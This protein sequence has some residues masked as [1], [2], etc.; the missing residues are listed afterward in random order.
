MVCFSKGSTH[1]LCR[2]HSMQ[3][4]EAQ[5]KQYKED[6]YVVVP[7]LIALEELVPVRRRLMELL[8][9][10]HDWPNFHFQVLDPERFRNPRGGLVPV[11]VQGPAQRE[12]IFKNIADH[13][14]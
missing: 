1:T 4:T 7:Q 2:R 6:G 3:L 11:G 13:P 14:H 10:D 5:L 8:E 12:E 9:G